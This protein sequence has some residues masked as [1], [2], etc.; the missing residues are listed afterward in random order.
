MKRLFLF[1]IPLVLAGCGKQAFAPP[2]GHPAHADT[3]QGASI[4]DSDVL[5]LA[6]RDPVDVPDL[7]P[8]D[9][10]MHHRQQGHMR[11]PGEGKMK[12][13]MDDMS[14]PRNGKEMADE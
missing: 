13:N 10:S 8:A 3:S 7:S 12:M 1:L 5:N 4:A 11:H 9:K 2:P 6:E 14:S